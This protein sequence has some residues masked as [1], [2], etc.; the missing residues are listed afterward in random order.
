MRACATWQCGGTSFSVP[1]LATLTL[2]SM[3]APGSWQA[4]GKT[5]QQILYTF[6]VTFL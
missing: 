1:P 5:V 3:S 2:E 6:T 4:N